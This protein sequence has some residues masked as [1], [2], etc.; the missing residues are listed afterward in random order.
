M[1]RGTTK[2]CEKESLMCSVSGGCCCGGRTPPTAA[3][4]WLAG[5]AAPLVV[6]EKSTTT[7]VEFIQERERR[8]AARE[9]GRGVLTAEDSDTKLR[10][11]RRLNLLVS[12]YFLYIYIYVCVCVCV[13]VGQYTIVMIRITTYEYAYNISYIG[14]FYN[15]CYYTTLFHM[16]RN[17]INNISLP[18]YLYWD[19]LGITLCCY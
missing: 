15:N 7:T 11:I 9:R 8:Q 14:I 3:C 17:V 19:P 4:R 12:Q 16:L 18:L 10:I 6:R 13:C 1:C 2:T 5:W